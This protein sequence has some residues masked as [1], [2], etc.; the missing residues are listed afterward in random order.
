MPPKVNILLAT[1]NG[2]RFLREQ[3]GSISSQT[4]PFSRITIRDDGSS[5]DTFSAL[6]D[7]AS[8]RSNVCLSRGPQLGVTNNFFSLL[9]NAD[10]DSEY[11]AFA[12]QDDVW[13]PEKLATAVER[14]RDFPFNEPALYA[15]RVEY[16]GEALDHLGYSRSPCRPD[17]ANALV[18]NIAPGCTMVLNRA[19]RNLICDNLPA[20]AMIHDWWC[21]LVVAAVGTVIYDQWPSVKYRQHRNNHTGGTSSLTRL[22]WRRLVRLLATDSRSKLLST[23]AIEFERLYKDLLSEHRRRVL[24][25][26]LDVRGDLLTRLSYSARMD[27][28]RQS[29]FDTAI[30][31]TL[32]V[33]GRI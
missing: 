13:H 1:F 10:S 7:W 23:Q 11:F 24:D 20:R 32:V 12:D 33:I 6:Q 8:C 16:V 21:Y 22:L 27:V 4:L 17:F 14:L 18:E 31:R 29:R 25:R 15:S 28:W 5:D 2:A 30:L 3:L 9:A 26:F 19:A